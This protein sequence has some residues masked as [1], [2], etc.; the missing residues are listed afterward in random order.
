MILGYTRVSTEEQFTDSQR[1]VILRY[2]HDKKIIVD[3][4]IDI[5]ISSRKSMEQRRIVEMLDG[6][7][8]GDTIIVSELSRLARSMREVV[9]IVNTICQVKK[10]RL[11]SILN[12]L[13]LNPHNSEDVTNT[14]MIGAFAMIAQLERAFI[15]ERTKNG[16]RRLK[17]QGIKLGKPKGKL[18]KSVYDKHREKIMHL[19][20]LGVPTQ[21]IVDLHLGYG[22]KIGVYK[23]IHKVKK[24]K[25]EDLPVWPY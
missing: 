15:R 16:L 17:A 9:D 25:P 23:Y 10:C 2:A 6:L 8:E 24:A 4:F 5:E 12:N 19:F 14:V 22:T 21:K 11:V 20:E 3:S 7:V 1:D 13:D 18:Q